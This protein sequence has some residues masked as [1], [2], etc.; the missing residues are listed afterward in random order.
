MQKFRFVQRQIALF[1]KKL[2]NYIFHLKCL[3]SQ[4]IYLVLSLFYQERTKLDVFYFFFL[5]Q[6]DNSKHENQL[7]AKSLTELYLESRASGR[8]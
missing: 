5:K 3:P 4:I 7:F 1:L 8:M 2:R 6:G